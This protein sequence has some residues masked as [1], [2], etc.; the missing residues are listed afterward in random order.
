MRAVKGDL[1][2]SLERDVKRSGRLSLGLM[3]R[4]GVP[5]GGRVRKPRAVEDQSAPIP[6]ERTSKLGK[7][8]LW[9][10]LAALPA[11]RRVLARRGW[12]G[13]KVGHFEHPAG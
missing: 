11:E 3:A 1:G 7:V 6:E 4:L 5:V 9:S 10:L 13:E 2:H 8:N 12:A